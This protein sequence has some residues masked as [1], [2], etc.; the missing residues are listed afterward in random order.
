MPEAGLVADIGGTHARF[1]LCPAPGILQHALTLA[2]ADHA[3]LESAV[4]AYLDSC[5]RPAVRRA[6][7]GIANPVLGDQIRMT[8]A[9][10]SFSIEATRRSLG[11][12]SLKVINDFTAL[13]L[14]LPLLAP[15]DL[16]AIGGGT[17]APGAPLALLGPGT[18]LG[19]SALIPGTDGRWTPLSGEGGHV[20]FAPRDDR[21]L[22]LWQAA[23]AHFGHVSTER[24]LSGA[25]LE[26]IHRT[27]AAAARDPDTHLSAARITADA[28]H[29]GNPRCLESLDVFCAILGSAAADLVLT[30]GA[31]GGVYIGGGIVPKLG[32]YFSSSPFRRRFEDK[33]RFSAY[34]AAVPAFVITAGHA[35]LLGAA[36]CLDTPRTASSSPDEPC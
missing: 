33:G 27:L 15:A 8:N 25:G 31:R 26:F 16:T 20:D 7:F 32:G 17:A 34:L 4:A 10:W 19:V 6:A 14:A 18:G 13:A 12:D 29:D 3:T 24:L 36:T 22:L 28:L 2:L 21:E 5:G 35:A 11:L 9:S 30:L 1:A 23:R